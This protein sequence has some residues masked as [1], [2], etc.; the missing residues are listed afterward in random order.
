MHALL[1]L[2]RVTRCVM[3]VRNRSCY[4][5]GL[6]GA[7]APEDLAVELR[8]SLTLPKSLQVR[9]KAP[10]QHATACDTSRPW[11]GA[12]GMMQRAL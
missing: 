2:L 9:C 11:A 6:A 1:L 3:I 12:F 10:Q 8:K 5:R 4:R 7:P